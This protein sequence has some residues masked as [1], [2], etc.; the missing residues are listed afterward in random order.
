[1]PTPPTFV[2]RL[3]RI[4]HG[5][6]PADAG[7]CDLPTSD[8]VNYLCRVALGPIAF[9][10]YGDQ[11][12]QSDPTLFSVLQS[13][14]LTVRVFYGQ[15]ENATVELARELNSVGVRPTLLK[16]ISAS[17]EFY[18]PPYLRLM[19]DVDI[20][21]KPSEVDLVLG[22]VEQ[23][24]YEITDEEWRY[25]RK[26]GHHHVPEARHP[27]TGVYI[28][29][30]T[31]LF[32]P[33]EFYSGEHVFQ[34]DIIEGQ[35]VEFDYRG[36]R[37][38]RFTPEFQFIYTVSKWSVDA[39]WAVNM[40]NINDTIHILR[41]YESTF[42]WPTLSKWFAASPHLYPITAALLHYLEQADL[43]TVSPQLREALAGAD[44]KLGPRRLKFLAW[45]LNTYPFNAR[46]KND[47]SYEAW[48]AHALWL[49]LTKPNSRDLGIPREIM[50]QFCTNALY[51]KYNPFRR[52]QS[53][54][55]ALVHRTKK[56]WA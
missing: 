55:K 45:L 22:K 18:S 44:R 24:G 39:N 53:G 33:A 10:V 19:G 25:Y 36:I 9:R 1:M 47:D 43:V 54:L 15:Y 7:S 56:K 12:R 21:I 11:L 2:T 4:Y 50:R 52:V 42:D 28:E 51:G 29:V 6:G 20:L 38:A 5:R 26:H 8:Q 48:F 27:K 37:V 46:D 35:S 31:G 3:L 13:A 40:K 41:K 14:D 32:S 49:Y 30:H 34:P 16:G 17:E 23:L